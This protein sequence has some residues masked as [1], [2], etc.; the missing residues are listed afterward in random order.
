M[1]SNTSDYSTLN[2]EHNLGGSM[3]LMKKTTVMHFE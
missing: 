2:S 3:Y 1:S